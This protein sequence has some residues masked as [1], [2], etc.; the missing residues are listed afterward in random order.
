VDRARVS[1]ANDDVA[2]SR[3]ND[4]V[5]FA[6]YSLDKRPMGEPGSTYEAVPYVGFKQNR[7]TTYDTGNPE[8]TTT[9]TSQIGMLSA[10]HFAHADTA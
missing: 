2:Q 6:G 1:L 8:I 4:V 3:T 5:V 7:V 9:R 10:I